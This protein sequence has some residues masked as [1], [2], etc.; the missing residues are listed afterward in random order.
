M[1]C[2]SEVYGFALMDYVDAV[3]QQRLPTTSAESERAKDNCDRRPTATS[4]VD[5]RPSIH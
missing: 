5:I 3:K 2:R 1:G 4:S